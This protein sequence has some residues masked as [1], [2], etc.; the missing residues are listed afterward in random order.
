[1]RTCSRRSS[2]PVALPQT[3]ANFNQKPV[4]RFG[5]AAPKKAAPKTKFDDQYGVQ[6]DHCK[7]GFCSPFSSHEIMGNMSNLEPGEYFKK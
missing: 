4:K 6:F 1:L 2:A 3:L 5:C 7:G